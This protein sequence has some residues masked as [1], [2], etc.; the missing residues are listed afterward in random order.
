MFNEALTQLSNLDFEGP[1]PLFEIWLRCWRLGH[2]PAH[3]VGG[4]GFPEFLQFCVRAPDGHHC[5]PVAL[6]QSASG[7]E[8]VPGGEFTR[9]DLSLQVIEYAEIGLTR[10]LS[11]RHGNSVHMRNS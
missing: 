2:E 10:C 8:K 1:D 5:Y 11:V 9:G 3:S 6:G 7:G 4:L